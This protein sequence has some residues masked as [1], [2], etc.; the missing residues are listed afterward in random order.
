MVR[1]QNLSE[2][3]QIR[4]GFPPTIAAG[5]WRDE[6]EYV[7]KALWNFLLSAH[8]K[9]YGYD[10]SYRSHLL[11]AIPMFVAVFCQQDMNGICSH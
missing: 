4:S 8:L 5:E 1:G 2:N 11:F 9:W 6:L 10:W 3:A 7:E